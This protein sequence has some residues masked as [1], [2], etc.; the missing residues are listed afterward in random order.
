MKTCSTLW[1]CIYFFAGISRIGAANASIISTAEPAI[2]VLLSGLVLG[3]EL[4]ILQGIG[5]L[6]IIASILILQLYGNNKISCNPTND[7]LELEAG[8]YQAKHHWALIDIGLSGGACFLSFL[9][10]THGSVHVP[11]GITFGQV[12]TFII[13]LLACHE[14]NLQFGDAVSEIEFERH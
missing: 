3:E 13:I 14:A 9:I 2:T 1:S 12:L 8:T 4:T 5:G 7:K 10:F 11:F 6:L